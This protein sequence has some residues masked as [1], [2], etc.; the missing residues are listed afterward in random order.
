MYTHSLS[1]HVIALRGGGAVSI[2]K[3]GAVVDFGR[4]LK[5]CLY[6]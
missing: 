1:A 5:V 3:C 4:H 6:T 2:V